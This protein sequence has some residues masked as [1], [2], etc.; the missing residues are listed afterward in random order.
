MSAAM[1]RLLCASFLCLLLT[2]CQEEMSKANSSASPLVPGLD[3][4]NISAISIADSAGTL[5][6]EKRPDGYWHID[7]P[8]NTPGFQKFISQVLLELQNAKRTQTVPVS[9]QNLHRL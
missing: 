7:S 4:N 5:Q 3:I 2:S 6:L 9:P 8:W 1:L